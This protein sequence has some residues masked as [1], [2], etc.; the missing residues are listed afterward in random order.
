MKVVNNTQDNYP[1]DPIRFFNFE[2]YEDRA[3]DCQLFIGGWPHKS[4]WDESDVPKYFFSTE[5]QSWAQD[6]TDQFVPVVDK[7]FTI[8]PPSVTGREKR[9]AAFFPMNKALVPEQVDKKYDVIYTGYATG[10]HV[11]VILNVI[12]Q[13]KYRFV[14][15]EQKYGLVTDV[16]ASYQQK[17][18]LIA[19]SRSCVVHNLTSGYSPQLKSRP[20]EAAFC[21]SLMLVKRDEWNIIEQWFEPNVDFFYYSNADE[22]KMLIRYGYQHQDVIAHAY[23]K[24]MNEYTTEKFIEKYIGWK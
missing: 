23:E 22:L 18:R 7:I 14:S 20:F 11:E 10:Q 3:N 8:C 6:G 19:D 13:F 12:R 16:G 5:E 15:F 9:E 4:I 2:E 1:E 21:Q 17:L 24:A